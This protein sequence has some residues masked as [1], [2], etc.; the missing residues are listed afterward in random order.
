MTIRRKPS[1]QL[2]DRAIILR[3]RS[4]TRSASSTR[5]HQMQEP[6]D[7]RGLGRQ[8]PDHACCSSRPCSGTA[9]RRP[10]FILAVSL[11]LWFTVLF[12]NF[13]EAMAEGRGKAQADTLRKARQDV[14]G[15]DAWP[16]PRRGRACRHRAGLAAAQ[17]RRGA[18]RGRR[19]HPRRRRGIEGVASV[20]ESAITGEI[21][22]RSS[23]RA[24]A[25]A[26]PSP[27]ARGCSPTGWSS[28]SPPTPARPSWTA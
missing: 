11:W 21:A 23:A 12:A 20:D 24:A 18:G 16:T 25:T 5:A 10:W 4:W 17:G 13:A 9:R 7:V 8:R 19:H 1:R 15:Q 3:R 2:F 6:G 27:A 22:P 28:A 14:D 26:A